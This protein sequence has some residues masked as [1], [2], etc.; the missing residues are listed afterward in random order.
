MLKTG[1]HANFAQP[2]TAF[3]LDF[4]TVVT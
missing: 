1:A 3:P 4:S 2:S